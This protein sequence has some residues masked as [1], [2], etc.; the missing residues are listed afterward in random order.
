M[1]F[2]VK[3][4]DIPIEVTALHDSTGKFCQQYFTRKEPLF[5]VAVQQEEID[6]E[7][8]KSAAE[9]I[10][11]GIPVCQ[12]SD[13]YL[14][15]L[16][17]YRKVAEGLLDYG[18]LLFHGSAVAVDGRGYLF[19]AASGTGKST[20]VRLWREQFGKR[21]VMINDDK[22][23][24][25]ITAQGVTA[26]GTPWDGKHRLSNNLAAPLQGLC[27]LERGEANHIE[28]I[29]SKEAWPMLLQQSFRPIEAEGLR[30]VMGLVDQLASGVDLYR[31]RCNMEPEAAQTA[32]QGMQS[33]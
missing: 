8:E 21:A 16:A 23:L 6:Y 32:F 10:R 31:L 11:Q 12:Y 17:V 20:H 30:K 26:Y 29:T 25:R 33:I 9:D 14:E 19:T 3:L 1:T 5:A 13:R 27:I 7:R 4:A 28:P 24:L 18:V 15:T 2:R 22:P